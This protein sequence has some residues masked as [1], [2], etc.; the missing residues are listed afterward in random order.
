MLDVEPIKTDYWEMEQDGVTAQ[1]PWYYAKDKS[2][3]WIDGYVADKTPHITLFYGFLQEASC[4]TPHIEHLLEDT[5][6]SSIEIEDIDYFDS[7]YED[8]P[9]YCVVAKVKKT[10]GLLYAH[11]K[12]KLLPNIQTY[13]DYKPHVTLGYIVKNENIR[14]RFIAHMKDQLVGKTLA[15]TWLNY[16]GNK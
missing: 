16:W 8:E 11:N 4:F 6:I 9:Y 13:P 15:V 12:M 1:F 10:E 14:D 7:P 2:R 5:A 3:F